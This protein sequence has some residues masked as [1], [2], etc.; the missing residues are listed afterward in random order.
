MTTKQKTGHTPGPWYMC[1]WAEHLPGA[2]LPSSVYAGDD[3]EGPEICRFEKDP[4]LIEIDIEE[5]KANAHLA[6]AAPELLKA[7]QDLVRARKNGGFVT[8]TADGSDPLEGI[9]A[10]IARATGSEP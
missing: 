9:C 5:H 2:G 10:A 3:D 1:T 4:M 8:A 7:C 6:V